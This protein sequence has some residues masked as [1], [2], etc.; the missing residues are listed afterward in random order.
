MTAPKS[1][2]S[3]IF[4]LYDQTDFRL[5]LKGHYP[6]QLCSL[7]ICPNVEKKKGGRDLI[8]H[9]V[10]FQPGQDLYLHIYA[11]M[12]LFLDGRVSINDRDDSD[13]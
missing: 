4:G 8:F 10:L 6:V 2:G 3:S 5:G 7:L 13:S 11:K 12:N 9:I 1:S